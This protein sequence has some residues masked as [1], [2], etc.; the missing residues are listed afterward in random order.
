MLYSP[1]GE[2]A[3]SYTFDS[4]AQTPVVH[5]RA[6]GVG[7]AQLLAVQRGAQREVLSLYVGEG[8][9]Q[10]FGHGE[11]NRHGV[12]RCRTHV[13]DLEGV[14]LERCH[15]AF[16][17]RLEIIERLQAVIALVE[18]LA[19]GRAKLG[20]QARFAR[21]APRTGND[22]ATGPQSAH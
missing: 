2:G 18:R 19:S 3:T 17:M 16:S 7:A 14:K 9:L 21:A 8:F 6:D 1:I 11:G 5:G 22:R 10:V 15:G 13:A 12:A 4:N 20:Q